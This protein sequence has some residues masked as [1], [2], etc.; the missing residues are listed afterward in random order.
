M[1]SISPDNSIGRVLKN[2]LFKKLWVQVPQRRPSPIAS[3]QGY[4]RTTW[5]D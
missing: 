2:F 4:K 1:E 3:V 5:T